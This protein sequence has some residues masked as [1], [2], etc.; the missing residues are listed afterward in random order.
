M[1][2]HWFNLM[3]W[4]YLPDDFT[5]KHRSVWVDVDSRL[6]DARKANRI[7]NDYLDLL[8][9]AEDVGYDGL[10][11]NEHHQNA[12]GLMPSPQLMAATLARRTHRAA[13]LLLGQSLA[14]YNPPTRVA[15]EMAMIDCISGGRL[16]SGFP[17][18]S[19]M[20]D[21]YACGVN[22][23][24]LREHLM[25]GTP[26]EVIGKLRAYEGL[27]VDFLYCASYGAPIAD[28]KRSLQ[29]F[30]DEVTPAFADSTV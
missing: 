13:I 2:F 19:S 22:P 9:L 7:Y 28:Q 15:E 29:L 17:V 21:N 5:E 14:L 26:E 4:P 8:E 12:Y 6:F 24:T 1:K 27:G 18:G 3:P 25:F 20:D 11:I 16:I 23:A 30:I 10:G